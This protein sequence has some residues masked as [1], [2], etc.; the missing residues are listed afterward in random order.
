MAKNP[1]NGLL[2]VRIDTPLIKRLKEAAAR[3]R[4]PL[5]SWVRKALADTVAKQARA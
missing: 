1:L 4:R 2:R 5:S 3:D